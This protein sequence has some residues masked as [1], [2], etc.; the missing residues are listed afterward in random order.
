MNNDKLLPM[1]PQYLFVAPHPFQVEAM[2]LTRGGWSIQELVD[3]LELH[4]EGVAVRAFVNGE[5]I[6]PD[7]WPVV[8]PPFGS[9][10]DI[11][12][13]P[14]G[15]GGDKDPLR[16][17]LF[18]GVMAA[19]IAIGGWVAAA[20]WGGQFLGAAAAAATTMVGTLLVNAIAPPPEPG[21]LTD[22]AGPLPSSAVDVRG[23]RNRA[24]PYG[25]IPVVLGEYRFAPPYGA[26]PYTEIVGND[27][28]IRALFV[29]GYG[30]VE[31]KDLQIGETSLADADYFDAQYSLNRGA[32]GESLAI[33]CAPHY[34]EAVNVE[35]TQAGGWITRTTETDTDIISLDFMFPKGLVEWSTS[36]Q[37]TSRT[38][39][40]EIQI[41]VADSGEWT[42]VWDY[43]SVNEQTLGPMS[44]P[45]NYEPWSYRIVAYQYRVYMNPFTGAAALYGPWVQIAGAYGRWD[46][47]PPNAF[48][49]PGAC[50]I[51]TIEIPP[52]ATSITAGMITDER[53]SSCYDGTGFQVVP[54]SPAS[55]SVKVSSGSIR[56]RP[57]ATARV[58]EIIYKNYNWRVSQGKY[59]VRVRRV[60]ADATD[61]RIFDSL[62]WATLRSIRETT[63]IQKEGLALASIR[64]RAT[65]QMSGILD[66]FN[67]VVQS[68]CKDWDG[69]SWV[70][71]ATSNPASLFRHVLQ[72]PANKQ[73]VEDA[74]I[75][76]TKLQEWHE[77]CAPKE[78]M[79]DS[80]SVADKGGG[81]VGLPCTGH[82]FADNE[83]IFI[84]GTTNYDGRYTVDPASSTNEIVIQATYVAET[85]DGDEQVGSVGYEYNAVID[86]QSTVS[87]VLHQIAA[88]GRASPAFVDGKYTVII[89]KPQSTPVQ[90]FTP[91]NSW[92]FQ[93]KKEFVKL[94]HALRVIFANRWQFWKV[95][96]RIV[97][98]DGYNEENA[99]LYERLEFPGVTDPDQ[100]YNLARYHLAVAKLRPERYSF[101]ADVENL[102]AT[103]G[104]LIR[105]THDVPLWGVA[106]GRIKLRAESGGNVTAVT[107][108]SVMTMVEGKSYAIR[109]R[110]SDGTSSVHAVNLDVGEQYT[111]TFT[112][113]IPIS[114]A[115]DVGDLGL[116]GESSSESVQL[117]IHSIE[118]G[119]NLT[120]KIT[121]VDYSPN[122]YSATTLPI[123]EHESQIT[124]PYTDS[125]KTGVPAI[126]QIRSDESVL[127]RGA[128]GSLQPR[129]VISLRSASGYR[130][131]IRWT[132]VHYRVHATS[133]NWRVGYFSGYQSE[134]SLYDVEQGIEYDIRVRY[135]LRSGEL[136]EFCSTQAHTVIGKSSNPGVPSGVSATAVIAG[137]KLKWTNPVDLDFYAVG[138]WRNTSDS[139]PGGSAQFVVTGAP[140]ETMA[141]VDRD[142]SYDQTYYYWL[143]AYDTSDNSST[144]TSSVNAQP[145]R[146]ETDDVKD[147][148]ITS[149]KCADALQSEN[150][151]QGSAG[152][153]IGF[154]GTGEGYAEFNDVVIRGELTAGEVHI[155]DKTTASSFHVDTDGDTW[156]GCNEASF[157]SDPENA[158]AYVLKDGTAKF[159]SG[160]IANWT[161]G[162]NT[163]SA[164]SITLNAQ[165]PAIMLGAATAYMSGI[166]VWEGNDGDA[167]KWRVGNPAGG[168]LRW[169]GTQ[170]EQDGV[171]ISGSE[172]GSTKSDT[173][174]I[175][176]DESDVNVQLILDRFTGGA[177]TFQ[178]NGTI[179]SLDQDFKV[180]GD[181]LYLETASTPNLYIQTTA[182][183]SQDA[184]LYIRG[185]RTTATNDMANIHLQNN[186]NTEK[187]LAK[188]AAAN[189][190]ADLGTDKGELRFYTNTGSAV[191]LALTLK[192][193]QTATFGSSISVTDITISAPSSVY[194]LDHDSFSGF[195]A[196]EHIP[197]STVSISA[198]TGLSGGG[199]IAANRTISLSHLGLESLSDPGADRI[200]I[201]DD[202]AGVVAWLQL[203]DELS[204]DA[205][206]ILSVDH[207]KCTNFVA[208][209]HINHTSV[210]ITAGNGLTGGGTIAA[211]RTL[212][213]GA[214]NGIAVGAD[215]VS[216]S[217]LG[218]ESLSDPGADR[219]MFWDDSAGYVTWLACGNSVA[220]AT[221]TLDTIQDIR[222][223]ASPTFA[224]LTINGA[225][226]WNLTGSSVIDVDVTIST[227]VYNY[228]VIDIGGVITSATY[229]S[230]ATLLTLRT[231]GG[232]TQDWKYAIRIIEGMDTHKIEYGVY[233]SGTFDT[234]LHMVSVPSSYVINTPNWTVTGAG[235]ANFGGTMTLTTVAAAGSDVDKFLVL[236]GSG[237]VDYRTGTELLSDLS[238]DA[239]SAFN[240]NSQNVEDIGELDAVGFMIGGAADSRR[241]SGEAI[242]LHGGTSSALLSVQ[243]GN[244]RIQLKWNASQGSSETYLT[245]S[246]NAFF[247]DMTISSSPIW[248]MKYAAAGTANDPITWSVLLSLESSGKLNTGGDLNVNATGEVTCGSINRA[249]GTLTL[250]IGGAAVV[251]VASGTVSMDG[252]LQFTGAQSITTSSGNL[253]LAPAGDLVLT[254][255]GDVYPGA[256]DIDLGT[257]ANRWLAIHGRELWVQTLVA[258]DVLATLGGHIVTSPTSY[259]T[260]D[261][262]TTV[263]TITVQHNHFAV[264][265][266]VMMMSKD[267]A[268]AKFEIMQITGGPT[269]AGP[270][271]Y[272]VTRNVDLGGADSWYDGDAVVS[273][274]YAASEGWIE[275]YSVHAINQATVYGPTVV[276]WI[277]TATT[278]WNDYTAGWA[279][280]N[281]NG[282]YGYS[283]DVMGLGLG[284]YSAEHIVIDPTNGIRFRNS[285]TVMGQLSSTTWT[286]G[287]TSGQNVEITSGAVSIKQGSDTYTYLSSGQLWLGLTSS[288]QYM[289]IDSN[290]VRGY[291]NFSKKFELKSTGEAYVGDTSSEHVA[292]DSSGVSL[293]DGGTL[294]GRFAL[295]TTLGATASEHIEITSAHVQ[296]KDGANV[297]TD[298][299]AGVLKLG[300]ASGGEYVQV[301]STGIEIY[302]NAVKIVEVT[303]GGIAYVGDQ[304]NEHVKVS[305]TGVE[306]KDGATVYGS[307]AATTTIGNT[308]DAHV[309]I[310]ATS[311]QLKNGTTI[312]T[313]ITGGAITLGVQ[314]GGEYIQIDSTGVE[315]YGNAVKLLELTSAGL[316]YIGNQSNEH[317]KLSS[318]GVECK[319]GASIY[320]KFA[321]TT[322]IG[323]TTSEH[324]NITST[325]VQIKDGSN[326]YTD[327]TAGV[328]KLGLV[329][330]GEY[331]QIDSTGIEMYGNGI[332]HVELTSAGLF[333]AGDTDATERIQWDATKGLAIY[334]SSGNAV[335]VAGPSGELYVSDMISVGGIGGGV[336]YERFDDPNNDFDIRWPNTG[337]SGETTIT[338]GGLA[339]GKIVQI[340]NNAG[341]DMWRG[342]HGK[343]IPYDENKLYRIRCRIRR[344]AGTGTCYLGVVGRNSTDTAWVNING[345][346]NLSSQH[347]FAAAGQAPSDWTV[348]TGYFKGRAA[349]GNGGQHSDPSDPGT[350]HNDV[351]YFRPLLWV[352]YSSVAG[353]YE[354][355]E[356]SI[357]IIPE[358]LD[359]ISDGSTY[360]RVLA[361]DIS[362]GHILLSACS[363]DLD[364]IADGTYGKVLATDISAGHIVLSTCDGDL[365]DITDGTTYGKL[366]N[367]VL[368]SGYLY[369]MRKSADATEKIEVTASGV[370]LYQGGNKLAELGA[371][372]VKF[373]DASANQRAE[374]GASFWAGDS[375]T[376]ER[377]Q[378][379]ST[380][381]LQIFNAA[382]AAR[383]SFPISGDATISGWTMNASTL[384]NSTHIILDASNK[385]ISIMSAAFGNA[386]IQLQ[387]NAG[388]PKIYAGDGS[389][390]YIK[391]EAGSG[392]FLSTSQANAITIK[393]GG[394]IKLEAGG[395]LILTGA[396]SNASRIVFSGTSYSTEFYHNYD[397][398]LTQINPNTTKVTNLTVGEDSYRFL[399]IY[400]YAESYAYFEA[401]CNS[402]AGYKAY[403]KIESLSSTQCNIYLATS[404]TNR[405]T[406]D[407][408]GN[409]TLSQIAAATADTDKFLVSDTGVIKYRTGDQVLSDLGLDSNLKNLTSGEISQLENIGTTSISATQWGYLGALNQGLTTTSA[410]TF[411]TV[412]IG[413]LAAGAADY[414][415]FLV[416][417]SGLVK[418][419]TGAQVLSDIGAAASSHTHD[420][421]TLQ[422]DGINS[423]GGAFAFTTTG[424]VTFSQSLEIDKGSG[425]SVIVLDTDGVD[426]FTLGV[427]SSDSY[428]FKINDGGLLADISLL[429]IESDGD[430]TL[431]ADSGEYPNHGLQLR[432]TDT[433]TLRLSSPY[434]RMN[435]GSDTYYV[436]GAGI[437]ANTNRL[438]IHWTDDNWATEARMAF[439]A[440]DMMTLDHLHQFYDYSASQTVEA[441]G[442]LRYWVWQHDTFGDED[443]IQ[444]PGTNGVLTVWYATEMAIY[445]VANDASVQLL[446]S[447]DAAIFVTTDTDGK[448]CCYDAGTA[449]RVKNRTGGD[450][451]IRLEFKFT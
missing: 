300:L 225:G 316:A 206:P 189:A 43:V 439:F 130:A 44:A 137:I 382:N 284:K 101:Y 163:L 128:D 412:T 200:L 317:V 341:D 235:A 308:A 61:D 116:F 394:D 441:T 51:A 198:G 324:V 53:S 249:S 386:G 322:T 229:T 268:T 1:I 347:Y 77:F 150:Y 31:F 39:E 339:G 445:H 217:H 168:Y 438:Y 98:D 5:P 410:V 384:S 29:I 42:N 358:D 212:N 314:S 290:G 89:D 65:D 8:R 419:R 114:S 342:V 135:V 7:L 94:P 277:R 233:C 376:T 167:Y 169:T 45:V 136:T 99:T 338:T 112:T 214:G 164:G 48:V 91:R 210:S 177:A 181:D 236:D 127:Y 250:E 346:N 125:G 352:N 365:D 102:V 187:T 283:A 97:Y 26:Y 25:P 443:Y 47:V 424:V 96:E 357:D 256:A 162:T 278:N 263:T 28:Y 425:D 82:T 211:S 319:D 333:W 196:D 405:L 174:T 11:R 173:F 105:V 170:L 262:N 23:L 350:M 69:E 299:T 202:S 301:D 400:G 345:E 440:L 293:Y 431:Y 310:D 370:E 320:A 446:V 231:L 3:E 329:S 232:E 366:R 426:R 9:I 422:L 179:A 193:D 76:L 37:R 228:G 421:N 220:I 318:T 408:N 257:L 188:I 10:T 88:A 442:S 391:Y 334:D 398:T 303:S 276:G 234:F 436:Y 379:D 145:K 15:G 292:V 383:I 297:Y 326:V 313:D 432:S 226:D 272:T 270:Y 67:C 448:F 336:F 27:V 104:D 377:I 307:F 396:A 75:D 155:P 340:G 416:S 2:K 224:G 423:N 118:P 81:L 87:E 172:V 273:L 123:G 19:S 295:T 120:A 46:A 24:N 374:Y 413:S 407:Y 143:K 296:F 312:Y 33:Y 20:E 372:A 190:D 265:D 385:S 360:G 401:A 247:W 131:E 119:P 60:T 6:H 201:W 238:G 142:V 388:S 158:V 325:A 311:V 356:F 111:L 221:T 70:E 161:I 243:D 264:N 429:H 309:Y 239:N 166:G 106:V 176:S 159:V 38:V 16:T 354:V 451:A 147:Y 194:S 219:I 64:I 361:T 140:S 353:T 13:I 215:S 218:L 117:L 242:E 380:N 343:S 36:G 30:V 84:D 369:L 269:G 207:D 251:S 288:G 160:K 344:T 86:T 14:Q 415:K 35:L 355:D 349:S 121:C 21:Q 79:L 151:S 434:L 420:G 291:G 378:W 390:E 287:D 141:F 281:L 134:L 437:N 74:R 399:G 171:I 227:D 409:V 246:E 323:L 129:I 351:R 148:N 63:V 186:A 50:P 78:H 327:L 115:P 332:K 199:T 387:Y 444:L 73:A 328:L 40:W 52:E 433:G 335:I 449:A 271:D 294:Y 240:W 184:N 95:D 371:S 435:A 191:A 59:D 146:A 267:G 260:A 110:H 266:Y 368:D 113:P 331:V 195:V 90:H 92:G 414:D 430:V 66:T 230:N 304:V 183:S 149:A 222:T 450:V 22:L 393:N 306:L 447:T 244:G 245:S 192:T 258:E 4:R 427:D 54:T 285:T 100:A 68:V 254:P 55:M 175:N 403:V 165:T 71:R 404:N 417:D 57:S 279:L 315:G 395:D 381:G 157:I 375:S 138:I 411:G 321:A 305:S 275:Q 154:R 241:T 274:G 298:L 213:V 133:E 109:F 418:Y 178:W 85:L 223:S 280:G 302:G 32:P 373:Y 144:Q 204:I 17:F 389:N 205:T 93:G 392:V 363:G 152:W 289:V 56:C 58:N 362:A 153:Y 83:T 261:I 364:D 203:A 197:H 406:I 253:T 330:G 124:S 34:E 185:A 107:M 259:L 18:I 103:R 180:T 122:V 132:E 252:D 348:Y 62:Y 41:A 255:G 208:N 428:K 12:V 139:F 397:G 282:V 337:G 402:V 182:G 80:G 72:H 216:L 126:Y 209:E 237:N 156:W 49:P 359:Q 286:L 248:E 367:A 108:D